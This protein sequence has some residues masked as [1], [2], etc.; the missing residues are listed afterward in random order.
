ML[1]YVIYSDA[2]V[3]ISLQDQHQ[4]DKEK[5]I[6]LKSVSEKDFVPQI[7]RLFIVPEISC[8]QPV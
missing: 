7:D 3:F 2:I 8:T 1:C 6:S 5:Q 4:K